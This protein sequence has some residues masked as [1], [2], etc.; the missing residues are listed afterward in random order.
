M[1]LI[2][3]FGRAGCAA[4]IF[5]GATVAQAGVLFTSPGTHPIRYGDGFS[6]GS[7]FTVNSP[8]LSAIALG[9]YD[10]T[11]NG[12]LQ[13]HDVGLWDR[14]AGDVEVA[15]VTIPTGTGATLINGFRY[16]N[17][18]SP[19]ALIQGHQYILAAFYPVGEVA[20]VNDQLLDCCGGGTN[21]TPDGNFGSFAGA[22]TTP[23]LG[24]SAGHLTEPNGTVP[25]T[26]DYVGPNLE[27]VQ[28]PEPGTFALLGLG[29]AAVVRRRTSRE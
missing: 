21:A 15:Q 13:S 23:G 12:F 10:T 29:L 3:T 20:G 2:G 4:L 24:S 6:L 26:T 27:F 8:N 5:L 28:T 22:F 14:T 7:E 1:K 9:I 25:G 18:G 17:L 16:I 11:G 19:L